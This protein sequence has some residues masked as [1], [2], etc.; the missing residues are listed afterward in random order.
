MTKIISLTLVLILAGCA[1]GRSYHNSDNMWKL[2][3]SDTQL[4]ERV[5]R[6]SYAGY[7]IPQSECDDFAIMRASE[8]TKE[9]GYKYFRILTE[10]QSSQSQSFYIPGSTYTT[11]TVSGYG[12]TAQV[13]TTSYS[14]GFVGTANYPVST[15]TIEMLKEKDD[16]SGTL[17]A[18]IIWSSLAKKHGVGK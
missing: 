13:N 10:K 7:G 9:K 16:A 18:E 8:I 3:Y 11:G 14:T 17:D 2:G 15:I 1:T 12:N 6:V 4:N 5:Y